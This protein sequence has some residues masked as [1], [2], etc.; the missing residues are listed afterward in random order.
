MLSYGATPAT[1]PKTSSHDT[2]MLESM[3]L[4]TVGRISPSTTS[5]PVTIS[6]P[7]VRASSSQA[8]IRSRES[9]LITGPTS[10]ASSIGSP[11]TSASTQPAKRARK[12]S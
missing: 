4:S 3:P 6:A 8:M 9:R 5:P 11:T 7:E 2:F 1:G 12:S 10:V